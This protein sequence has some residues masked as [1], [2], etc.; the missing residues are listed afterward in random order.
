MG[1]IIFIALRRLGSQWAPST[2]TRPRSR[3][4]IFK[5]G[6]KAIFGMRS[7]Q[8]FETMI[9]RCSVLTVV[10]CSWEEPK[11]PLESSRRRNTLWCH[12]EMLL[13]AISE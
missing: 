8:L 6:L 1:G 3:C 4:A 9:S 2:R 10:S 13:E 7:S 12:S 11:D 5:E